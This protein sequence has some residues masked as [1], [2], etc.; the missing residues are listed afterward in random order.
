MVSFQVLENA[1]MESGTNSK[2][3]AAR[4]NAQW[5]DHWTQL[6]LFTRIRL[7]LQWTELG[8]TTDNSFF[9]KK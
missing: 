8:K 9:R 3:R 2:E 7:K 4:S 5:N 6:L 1:A